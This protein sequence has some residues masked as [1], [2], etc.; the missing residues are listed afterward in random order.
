MSVLPRSALLHC[1]SGIAA[2]MDPA[3]YLT[4]NPLHTGLP[5]YIR[6]RYG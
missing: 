3:A 5:T 6:Q 4:D 1:R 2:L